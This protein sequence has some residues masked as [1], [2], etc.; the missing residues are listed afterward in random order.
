MQM[1]KG[2]PI[3]TNKISKEEQEGV[4]HHL[5]DGIGLNEPTWTVTHFTHHALRVVCSERKKL[6]DI[7]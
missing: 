1:Y 5:L 4:P 3:I 7:C 2:L 6:S